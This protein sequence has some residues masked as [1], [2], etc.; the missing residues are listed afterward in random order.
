MT[1]SAGLLVFLGGGAGATIRYF[2]SRFFAIT[3]GFPW[4]TFAIN[5]LGSIL[6]GFLVFICKD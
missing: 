1:W 5:I 4:P 3:D 6:L 2:F